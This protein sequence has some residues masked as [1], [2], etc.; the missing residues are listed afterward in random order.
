MTDSVTRLG[1]LVP[2]IVVIGDL[3]ASRNIPARAKFQK[4]LHDSLEAL[5]KQNNAL[6]S[7]YTLTL[8]DEFQAVYRSSKGLFEDICRLRIACIPA[9]AR[10]SLGVGEIE[11]AINPH[12]SLGM[13]GPAF[14]VARTGI[15]TL[16][17]QKGLF[18]L[19]GAIPGDAVFRDALIDLVSANTLTWKPSRWSILA[20][21]LAGQSIADISRDTKLTEAA[22]YKNIRH[23]H[24]ESLT[25]VLDHLEMTLLPPRPLG[26]PRQP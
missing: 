15:E 6:A 9:R 19:A 5:S 13:D 8:G 7:P 25:A 18:A 22:V 24:L 3:V 4:R 11:T 14:H 12:Q 2:Y 20:G 23:A 26:K 21:L 16:K 17:A 1:G 10:I